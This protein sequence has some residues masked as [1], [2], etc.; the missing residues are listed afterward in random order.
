MKTCAEI[1][2]GV[3]EGEPLAMRGSRPLRCLNTAT[4]EGLRSAASG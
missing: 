1:A 2:R 3:E 4:A